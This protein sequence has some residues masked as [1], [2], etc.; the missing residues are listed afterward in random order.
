MPHLVIFV[1]HPIV[2][3]TYIVGYSSSL[4]IH[5]NQLYIKNLTYLTKLEELPPFVVYFWKVFS[6]IITNSWWQPT[7]LQQHLQ[8]LWL[9]PL[10]KHWISFQ[11]LSIQC[12]ELKVNQIT[13]VDILDMTWWMQH[14]LTISSNS[15][16][17]SC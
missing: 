14:M 7:Q 2:Y 15:R 16:L 5:M 1:K 4:L 12:H 8:V 6:T 9:Q 10:S 13:N 11:Y 3:I 17:G